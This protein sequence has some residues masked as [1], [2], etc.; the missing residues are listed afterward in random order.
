MGFIHWKA[1]YPGGDEVEGTEIVEFNKNLI[2][3]GTPLKLKV[4][5]NG[6]LYV[7]DYVTGKIYF[8]NSEID[9]RLPEDFTPK[10]LRWINYLQGAKD[11][12]NASTK[13]YTSGY[14]FGW[15]T[16]FKG[17]NIKRIVFIKLERKVYLQTEE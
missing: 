10:D 12:C 3:R 9:L 5:C 8:D 11:W 6:D 13:D 15:Q 2:T 4:D 16:T 1:L 14:G 7:V 17:K